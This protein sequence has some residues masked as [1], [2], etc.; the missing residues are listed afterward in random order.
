MQSDDVDSFAV[1][2]HALLSVGSPDSYKVASLSGEWE[3]SESAIKAEL[4]NLGTYNVW[5]V[6]PKSSGRILDAK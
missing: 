2:A 6:D 1:F 5:D 4:A 3:Q